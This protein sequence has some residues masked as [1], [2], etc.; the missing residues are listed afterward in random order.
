MGKLFGSVCIYRCWR[1]RR[2][3]KP[4]RPMLCVLSN[5]CTKIGFALWNI[6]VESW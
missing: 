2:K 3:R 1:A 4:L 5:T 6:A